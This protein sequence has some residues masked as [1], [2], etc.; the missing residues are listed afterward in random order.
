MTLLEAM[1][2]GLPVVAT[3]AGGT[4]EIV[5]HG[6]TGVLTPVGDGDAFA[7]GIE[8]LLAN[9]EQRKEKGLA[10]RERFIQNY[11]VESMADRYIECYDSIL[12]T[13]MVTGGR[14]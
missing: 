2:L 5:E 11:S 7:G 14:G 9:P 3:E 4:P 6:I 13:S 10:G 1:S 8:A 12:G